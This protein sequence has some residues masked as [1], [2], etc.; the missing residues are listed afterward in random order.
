MTRILASGYSSVSTQ[1]DSNEY[2]YN[3]VKMF[4]RNLC[5]LVLWTKVASALEG[6]SIAYRLLAVS[7]CYQ[8]LLYKY[9]EGHVTKLPLIWN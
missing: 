1:L 9:N 5:V 6:L 8:K 3:M 4:F 7:Q 2:Q